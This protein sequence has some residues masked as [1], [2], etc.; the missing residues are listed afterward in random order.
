MSLLMHWRPVVHRSRTRPEDPAKPKQ[1]QCVS[2]ERIARLAYSYWEARGRVHGY[3]AEDWLRAER[4][5]RDATSVDA[6]PSP[7][8]NRPAPEVA[9]R[10][11]EYSP[12]A[13]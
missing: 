5:L 2:R 1:P 8:A 6:A 12:Q 4:D 9:P 3:A 10:S 11:K 13:S 7:E